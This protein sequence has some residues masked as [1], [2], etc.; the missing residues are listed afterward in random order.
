MTVF[1]NLTQTLSPYHKSFQIIYVENSR[2]EGFEGLLILSI[3][4]QYSWPQLLRIS[5]TKS[6]FD[7]L[8]SVFITKR[9]GAYTF[10]K[11]SLI[12]RMILPTPKNE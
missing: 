10:R 6:G 12:C 7:Y 5:M 2:R 3:V 8:F 9:T 4:L 1:T 11:E